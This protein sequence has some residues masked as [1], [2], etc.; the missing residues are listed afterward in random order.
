MIN[1]ENYIFNWIKS[2]FDVEIALSSNFFEEGVLDSLSFAEL[3]V[4]LEEQ[5]QIEINFADIT[6]WQT[7]SSI[8]G[9]SDFLKSRTKL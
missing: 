9:L 3:V 8:N 2:K 7:V 6:D 4:E 1:L 5:L